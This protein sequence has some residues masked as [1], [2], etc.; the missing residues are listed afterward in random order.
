MNTLWVE[1]ARGWVG[2]R[3]GGERRQTRRSNEAHESGRE[4]GAGTA[5]RRDGSRGSVWR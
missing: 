4:P 1:S 2:G 3:E 5:A